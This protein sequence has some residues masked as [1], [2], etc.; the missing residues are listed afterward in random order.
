MRKTW[1][2]IAFISLLTTLAAC[3]DEEPQAT[4]PSPAATLAPTLTSES[5]PPSSAFPEWSYNLHL[6]PFDILYPHTS[7]SE[8]R[9]RLDDAIAAGANSVI[10]YIEEE[11]MYGT[12]VDEAGFDHILP[13]LTT[14]IDEAHDRNLHVIVYLNGL[15]VMA[16]EAVD[17]S[18]CETLPAETMA[19]AHP[20]W[21]QLD[22]TGK[23]IV[24][25]CLDSD[26]VMPDMEDA[27]V[28]P[29]SPYRDL[30]K[31]RLAS[32]GA[33]GVDA[34]YIDATFMPGLQIDEEDLLWGTTD[35]LAREH[36]QAQTGHEV[37]VEANWDD[38]A[39][40]AWLMWRHEV[41]RNYLG[42][43]A[44]AA[45]DAGM[46]PFWESSS[47]DSPESVHLAN[48]TAL[49]AL[50]PMGFSPEVEPEGDWLAAF[51]MAQSARDFAPDHP[52][53]Y[54]GWPETAEAARHEFATALSFS[55]TL[56]P[57][58]DAPYPEDAFEFADT[59]QNEIL[60][61]RQPYWGRV[62]LLYSIR[63]KDWTYETGEYFEAYDDAFRDLTK[64][65]I[66]FRVLVL[67]N[68]TAD[69]LAPF[70]TVVLPNLISISDAE[71][72]VLR[73]RNVIALDWENG[74]RD[75]NWVLR[76]SPL[77]WP[78]ALDTEMD[79]LPTGLP[80][81]LEAPETTAIT[82]YHD[83]ADDFFLF[84]VHIKDRGE[85]VLSAEESLAVTVH[86]RGQPAQEL[87]GNEVAIPVLGELT[88][89]HITP[90]D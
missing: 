33:S 57:T 11:H 38:P 85:I 36:F 79:D 76:D 42:D 84:A 18:T 52:M 15:E 68:L 51:R 73:D 48:E 88:V 67:E 83:G 23:P 55:N 80:F 8:I 53:I 81:D 87:H 13:L 71:Y 27:W 29:F 3:G 10:V 59:I 31:E 6:W 5:A 37:P 44:A 58:S 56:Y 19:R 70:D 41:I 60:S 82:F 50:N 14:L 21:L 54:L 65:H 61:Q 2:V 34:V 25:T 62:A 26:W 39:W 63:N 40:R 20:D 4:Y 16:H 64:A 78:G 35:P 49:T 77:D 32:L 43:L 46:V 9:D 12:F 7:E 72:A 22:L 90:A 47:N 66:P 17:P 1:M 69:A 45:W 74:L 75:E 89:L 24:Y 30:F 86:R 28:S